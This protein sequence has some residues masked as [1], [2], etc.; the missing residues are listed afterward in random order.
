M[1]I[2]AEVKR[3]SFAADPARSRGR[4]FSEEE[5]AS[6][7]AFRPLDDLIERDKAD[8]LCPKKDQYYPAPWEEA[9][10]QGKVYGIP[11]SSDNRILYYNRAMFKAKA[12]ELREAGLDPDRPPR[13]WSEL[14]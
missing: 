5:T 8:P 12:R 4:L 1:A 6:R 14:L 11:N 13:T 10:Y 9:T 7:N 3:A 2:L